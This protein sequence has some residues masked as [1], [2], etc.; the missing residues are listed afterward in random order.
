MAI[1]DIASTRSLGGHALWVCFTSA[2][3]GQK[4]VAVEENCHAFD[5]IINALGLE[6][7]TDN[8]SYPLFNDVKDQVDWDQLHAHYETNPFRISSDTLDP[9]L[10]Q[11]IKA[12]ENKDLVIPRGLIGN[13][14]AKNT[15]SEWAYTDFD[16]DKNA[17][18]V[19]NRA[20]GDEFTKK[21]STVFN[22]NGGQIFID[23]SDYTALA[24]IVSRARS[25]KGIVGTLSPLAIASGVPTVSV[26]DRKNQY[27]AK[28]TRGGARNCVFL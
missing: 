7:V 15:R 6:T 5:S 26:T 3:M 19:E 23:N 9:T 2:A 20:D 27:W 1:M 21:L 24:C 4:R 10:N 11:V 18:I 16:Q 25:V 17:V 28:R 13:A 14:I 12:L 22:L 8:G